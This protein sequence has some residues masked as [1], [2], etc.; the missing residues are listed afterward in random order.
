MS[1]GGQPGERREEP[2][3]EHV[4]E[5]LREHPDLLERHPGLVAE[6]SVPHGQAGTVSLVEY[7]VASL[8]E[9]NRELRSRIA[10]LVANARDNEDLGRRVH[11]LTLELVGCRSA[12]DVFTTLYH[13]LE[14]HFSTELS[15]VRVF[16]PP[17]DPGDAGL[18]EFDGS[19]REAFAAVLE[20]DKPVCGRLRVEQAAALFDEEVERVGSAALI[21]LGGA[22]PFGLLA[23]AARDAQRYHPGMG[24]V[25]LRQVGEILGVVL[26]AHVV[27]S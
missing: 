27:R 8:R 2:L 3:E 16:A 4:V 14:E 18:G 26:G 24:T 15:A 20:S 9:E 10:D 13:C 12:G 19:G 5:Y 1:A 11:L 21:P 17:A 22:R 23:V 6:L 7:Q 25:F